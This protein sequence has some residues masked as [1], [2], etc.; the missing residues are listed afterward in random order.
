MKR[1]IN[2]AAAA[3]EGGGAAQQ[4]HR[5]AKQCVRRWCCVAVRC[6]VVLLGTHL[7]ARRRVGHGAVDP[8]GGL[9]VVFGVEAG[10]E[11][12]VRRPADL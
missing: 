3:E 8:V 2:A 12:D 11:P 4:N 10:V 9:W 1:D 6:C 5:E 7:P